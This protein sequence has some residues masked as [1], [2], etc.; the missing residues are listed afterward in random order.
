M[1]KDYEKNNAKTKIFGKSCKFLVIENPPVPGF[2]E[3]I[4]NIKIIPFIQETQH[5]ALKLTPITTPQT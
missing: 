1:I 2:Y 4:S 5:K 3:Q